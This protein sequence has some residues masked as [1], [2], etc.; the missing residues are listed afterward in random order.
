MY[1]DIVSNI[2]L[3]N[4]KRYVVIKN[5]SE[6]TT[7]VL[8]ISGLK[9]S[10]GTEV[11]AL[12]SDIQDQILQ[13][14]NKQKN[15]STE[16]VPEVFTVSVPETVRKNRNFTVSIATSIG[17]VKSVTIQMDGTDDIYTLTPKNLSA[18]EIGRATCYNYSKTFKI[19]EPGTY[20]FTIKAF[21]ENG[22]SAVIHKTVTVSA[23]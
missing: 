5:T 20:T 3:D 14:F 9:L 15:S 16:F 6:D 10:A 13:S 23:K 7:S 22:N 18:V 19:K 11:T 21:D 4:G 12:D 1:Y 8:A 17:D 2:N